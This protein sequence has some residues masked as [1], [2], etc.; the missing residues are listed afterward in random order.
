TVLDYPCGVIGR[1]KDQRDAEP[2]ATRAPS[3][4]APGMAGGKGRPPPSRKE[5]EAA[6]KRPLVPTDRKAA[7]KDA[8][9]KARIQRDLEYK[10]MQT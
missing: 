1:S 8:R 7:A 9:T 4:P 5:A 10:A 2:A 6:N 3:A